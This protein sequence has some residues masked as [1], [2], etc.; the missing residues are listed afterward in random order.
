MGRTVSCIY[1]CLC[2]LMGSILWETA[3]GV[4]KCILKQLHTEYYVETPGL[5]R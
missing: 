5:E 4:P 1:I 3:G 2:V